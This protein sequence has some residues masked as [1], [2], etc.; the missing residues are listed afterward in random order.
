MEQEFRQIRRE[1]SERAFNEESAETSPFR[2]FAR[3]FEE[4]V[5]AGLHEPNAFAL[6]TA[7]LEGRPSARFVLMKGLDDR[8]LTFYTNYESR[9]GRE[10]AVNPQAAAVFWWPPLERQVRIEG[11]V[12]TVS[13]EESDAYFRSRPPGARIGA[14]ASHQSR[15]IGGRL[16]LEERIAELERRW[17]DGNI[18]RPPH[19]GGYRIMPFLFEFW[20]GRPSR[21]HDR[22][23]YRLEDGRWLIDRLAP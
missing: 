4:A 17:P 15:T 19:W 18:P 13:E 23:R 8:G 5:G 2:Q 21:L 3:W 7:D 22:I 12:E 14:W 16:L 9:K 6:A 11:T 1:Y 10:M 20:Q